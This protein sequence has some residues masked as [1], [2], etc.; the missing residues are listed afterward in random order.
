MGEQEDYRTDDH[1]GDRPERRVAAYKHYSPPEGEEAEPYNW[2]EPDGR[3]RAR[4]HG[5]PALETQEDGPA[6]PNHRGESDHCDEPLVVYDEPGNHH[7]HQSL[8]HVPGEGE[9]GGPL[10]GGP[11]HVGR[12]DVAATDLPHVHAEGPP[13]KVAGRHRAENVAE[14]HEK[15]P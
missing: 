12:A 10:P 2:C 7:G 13:D 14:Q 4:R 15:N 6:V 9:H 3:P 8:E 1:D 11:E 5:F